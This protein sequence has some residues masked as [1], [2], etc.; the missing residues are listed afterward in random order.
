MKQLK[1]RSI[2]LGAGLS[3]ILFS[4]GSNESSKTES[5]ETDSTS[6]S[7]TDPATTTPAA[8][9][10]AAN[11]EVNP[12]YNLMVVTHKVANYDKWKTSYEKH[13]SVR[14]AS[15]MHSY[16]IARMLPD[17]NTLLVAVK[18]DDMD[19]ATAFS[20]SP[21]L[22]AA[23]KDGG[24]VGTPEMHMYKVV[25]DATNTIPADTRVIRNITVKDW[26][27]WKKSFESG[28]QLRMDNGIE[29]RS[30]GYDAADN[31]KVMVVLAL[32]DTAKANAFWKSD[33]MKKRMADAG[34]VGNAKVSTIRI[35]ARY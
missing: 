14:T 9:A 12:P 27:A 24:V 29:D 28:R 13:D 4:C 20:K 25:Y 23:M 21:S 11:Y 16:V 8:P 1:M 3:L 10:T 15:G 2:I 18:S 34:V 6:M 30:Y 33:D 22:K 19:K 35:V 32:T 26:D 7:T 17:S 5:A 31:H